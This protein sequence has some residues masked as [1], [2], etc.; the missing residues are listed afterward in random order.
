MHPSK[1]PFYSASRQGS[2]TSDVMKFSFD[3]RDRRASSPTPF[4]PLKSARP[5]AGSPQRVIDRK[6]ANTVRLEPKL[7]LTVSSGED[8]AQSLGQRRLV[9]ALAKAPKE[10]PTLPQVG[11]RIN[12]RYVVEEKL[13]HGHFGW[14]YLVRHILLGQRFA[15]KILSPRVAH[16]PNWI[17]RF[18][19]EA[20][21]TC[22]PR[23]RAHRVRDRL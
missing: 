5:A 11:E 1:K 10:E 4:I 7:Q 6:R 17:M 18:R 3:H 14:V 22:H 9:E 2:G 23:P 19:E 16:D 15:M 21:L 13:G 20:R 12:E 8:V